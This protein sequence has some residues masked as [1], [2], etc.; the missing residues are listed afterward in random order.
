VQDSFETALNSHTDV[1]FTAAVSY[2]NQAQEAGS[3]VPA[4]S[5]A[6]QADVSA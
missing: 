4:Q 5:N 3:A 1:V 6:A 2:A